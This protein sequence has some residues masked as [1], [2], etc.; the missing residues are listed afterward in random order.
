MLKKYFRCLLITLFLLSGNSIA[1]DLSSFTNQQSIT[2]LK[3]VL[4][5]SATNSVGLLGQQGGFL[6]N[7]QVKIP[8]PGPLAQGE[9]ILRMVGMG[10]Q[11]DQLVVAMNQAAEAAVP[12]A[13][14]LIVNV[15]KKM[16]V[17]DAKAILSGGDDSAT[18]Y[19]RSKTEG[20]LHGKFLPIVTKKM[21]EV[22]LAQQYNALA[23]KVNSTGFL[24]G[25]N[26]K[27]ENYVTQKTLDGLYL[28]MAEQ[29]KSFR[30]NPVQ[31]GTNLAKKLFESL[32]Y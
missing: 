12:L 18:R 22:N 25:D 3:D 23:G 29:E 26:I 14:G 6:N 32:R 13:T 9:Q 11:A 4:Q 27:L 16:S 17:A 15:I 28:T 5:Q 19:F 10:K 30:Q 2:V 31:A 7:P 21:N 20:T 1:A 8:L 24:K